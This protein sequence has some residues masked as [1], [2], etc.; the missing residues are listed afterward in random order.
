MKVSQL[1]KVHRCLEVVRTLT[2]KEKTVNTAKRL[3]QNKQGIYSIQT[4]F[5]REA[6]NALSDKRLSY[7]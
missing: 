4:S 5:S 6:Y 3:L 2:R 7:H 1:R